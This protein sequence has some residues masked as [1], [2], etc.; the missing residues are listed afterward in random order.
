MAIQNLI[1]LEALFLL[2]IIT[3][4]RMRFLPHLLI[5]DFE[6]ELVLEDHLEVESQTAA[7]HEDQQHEI[8]LHE[9]SAEGGVEV[10]QDC[11]HEFAVYTGHGQV[12]L[13]KIY[14]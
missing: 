13:K 1:F 8:H 5:V 9:S 3:V 11:V 12:Y 10:G 6:V 2:I 14:K 7:H 4:F